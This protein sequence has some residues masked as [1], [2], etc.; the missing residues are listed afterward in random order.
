MSSHILSKQH[1]SMDIDM[2]PPG[3]RH[4]VTRYCADRGWWPAL[5]APSM[6]PDQL[7]ETLSPFTRRAILRQALAKACRVPMEERCDVPLCRAARKAPTGLCDLHRGLRRRQPPVPIVDR[8]HRLVRDKDLLAHCKLATA[9]SCVCIHARRHLPQS[10]ALFPC[11]WDRADDLRRACNNIVPTLQASPSAD[12]EVVGLEG[13]DEQTMLNF[14][15]SCGVRQ[16]AVATRHLRCNTW[17]DLQDSDFLDVVRVAEH[18][19]G[20]LKLVPVVSLRLLVACL[21]GSQHGRVE[22]GAVLPSAR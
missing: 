12:T 3:M 13:L 1:T 6:S 10:V 22:D 21:H 17:G 4:E 15:S 8:L 16:P 2:L 9:A 18:L 14:L 7:V 20:A 5:C 19:G 11:L